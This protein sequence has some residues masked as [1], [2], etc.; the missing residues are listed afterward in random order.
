MSIWDTGHQLRLKGHITGRLHFFPT[1]E[2]SWQQRDASYLV[3]V[4]AHVY[5]IHDMYIC[6][7]THVST[8]RGDLQSAAPAAIKN[9]FV[10][11]LTETDL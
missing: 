4:A 2:T 6:M 5:H 1:S 3:L 10:L 9:S 8:C 7:Y 11:F